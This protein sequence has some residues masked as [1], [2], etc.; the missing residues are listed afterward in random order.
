MKTFFESRRHALLGITAGFCLFILAFLLNNQFA[1]AD[2]LTLS[3]TVLTPSGSPFTDGGGVSV[4]GTN[5]TSGSSSSGIDENGNFSL[6]NLLPGTY[7]LGVGISQSSAYA[8]PAEQQVTLTTSVS[9]FQ[10]TV[11]MPALIGTLT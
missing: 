9:G 6:P 11:S 8:N 4:W 1:R 10:I 7:T 5:G 2:T 3:G